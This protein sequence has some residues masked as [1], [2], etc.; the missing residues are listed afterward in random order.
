MDDWA[1]LYGR[2]VEW[3]LEFDRHRDIGLEQTLVD[4]KR[5]ANAEFGRF[6]EENYRSWLAMEKDDPE[7]PVLSPG[8]SRS[9]CVA[10]VGG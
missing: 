9:L 6:V 5:E 1:E 8:L 4:Q 2:L 10:T 7:R 3:E